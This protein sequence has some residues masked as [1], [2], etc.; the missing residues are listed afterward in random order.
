MLFAMS[1]KCV[2]RPFILKK[3]SINDEAYLDMLKNWLMNQL[4][5][6]EPEDFIFL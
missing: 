1:K 4:H 5:E 6:K 3:A 2:F